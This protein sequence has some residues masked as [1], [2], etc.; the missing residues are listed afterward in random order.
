MKLLV[1]GDPHGKLPKGLTQIVKK[2]KIE[3]I[4]CV[5]DIP[6]V[7]KGFVS[8][9]FSPEFRK[10]SDKLFKDIV[11]KLCSYELPLLTLRGNM[12]L[13]K[14]TS[15]LTK[16]IF[17]K[18]K[19]LIYKK[20]GKLRI[21][22]QNFIFFDMIWEEHSLRTKKSLKLMKPNKKRERK[23][24]KLLKETKDSILI[25]HVPPYGSLDKLREGKHVG[26]KIILNMIKKHKP[27]YVFCGH[28]HEAKGKKKLGKTLIINAGS[29]GDYI[30]VDV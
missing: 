2:N 1:I 23:L 15:K 28:I 27:R 12:Y 19:N 11:K 18:Y 3:I 16:Q 24:N 29:R 17:R 22:R 5:G 20:T 14:D 9:A 30:V 10:K 8:G 21:N 25:S 26:S 7:P 6:P 13:R 4:V